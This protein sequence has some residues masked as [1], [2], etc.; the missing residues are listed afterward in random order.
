MPPS[1]I[2]RE[3]ISER[4]DRLRSEYEDVAVFERRKSVSRERFEEM[5]ELADDGYLGGGYCRIVRPP[6]R[7]PPLSETMPDSA[8]DDD[9]R[10]LYILGRG[11]DWWG[12]PGGGR[13]A[14]ESF[15]AAAYREVREEVGVECEITGCHVI[16]RLVVTCEET[17]REAHFAYVVFAAEYESGTVRIQPG[18]LNGAAWFA[19]PPE[20]LHPLNER[21]EERID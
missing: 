6:E 3:E 11:F 10:V 20:D 2:Q 19:E 4:I 21:V 15:E 18:E 12:A 14:G 5:V 7:Q 16:E 8:T 1:A 9:P 13:E 17:N